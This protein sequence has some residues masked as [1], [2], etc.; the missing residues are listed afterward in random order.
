MDGHDFASEVAGK[1]AAALVVQ[2]DVKVPEDVTVIKVRDTR[3]A[4]AFLSGVLNYDKMR[5]DGAL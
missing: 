2:E 3:E 4:L 5:S 1:G